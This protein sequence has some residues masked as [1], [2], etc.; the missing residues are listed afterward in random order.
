MTASV[1]AL[2]TCAESTGVAGFLPQKRVFQPPTTT[3]PRASHISIHY[4]EWLN[5]DDFI[6]WFHVSSSRS[7]SIILMQ[8]GTTVL[9]RTTNSR[10]KGRFLVCLVAVFTVNESGDLWSMPHTS[11]FWPS[12]VSVAYPNIITGWWFETIWKILVIWDA[13]SQCMEK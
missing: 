4:R 1:K 11:S 8:E 6:R 7:R 2:R 10:R 5:P 12:K 3:K 9:A 13:Y